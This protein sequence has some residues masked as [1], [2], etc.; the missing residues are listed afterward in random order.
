[1]SEIDLFSCVTCSDKAVPARI[2]QCRTPGSAEVEI[3]GEVLEIDVQ[4]V[5][6]VTTGDLVLVHQGVAISRLS[7]DRVPDV[8]DDLIRLF[9]DL[10][11]SPEV[12]P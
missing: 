11:A 8:R 7:S 4:L 3:D 10:A 9:P 2:L 6:S 5:G 12:R 1:M